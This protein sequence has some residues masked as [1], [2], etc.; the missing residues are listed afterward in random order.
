MRRRLLI[1][2]RSILL[3]WAA[4]FGIT[5]LVEGPL[6][7]LTA[8]FFGAHWVPTEQLALT[9][10]GLAATGWVIGRWNRLDAMVSAL[11]FAAMLAVWNFDLVP[12]NLPWLFRL[13][14]D[15]FQD[16]RVVEPMLTS[17]VTHAFLLGSL[18]AGAGLSRPAQ[19]PVSIAPD[20]T[21]HLA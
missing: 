13:I 8:R 10:A 12:I 5:Y 9:C 16:V 6:L 2:L 14:V 15:S 20:Q 1:S 4:L 3:G 7:L 17:L 19:L 11:I 18:L 21:N